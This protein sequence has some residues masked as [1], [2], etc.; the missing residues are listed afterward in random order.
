MLQPTLEQTLFID[1]RMSSKCPLIIDIVAIAMSLIS[2]LQVL[3][4]NI[5]SHPL[6]ASH[7][8]TTEI[9]QI[10]DTAWVAS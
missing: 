3:D 2:I 5:T 10:F 1:L 7:Q 6:P 4:Q 8:L 9:A